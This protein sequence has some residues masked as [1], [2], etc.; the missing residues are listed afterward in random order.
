MS[1][2][3]KHYNLNVEE[4]AAF[5][6]KCWDLYEADPDHPFIV[7]YWLPMKTEKGEPSWYSSQAPMLE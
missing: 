2:S 4:K 1:I 6:N 5:N 3:E 7:K